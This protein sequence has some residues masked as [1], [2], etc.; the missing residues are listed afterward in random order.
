MSAT[1]K[2]H[3]SNKDQEMI[4][5]DE[6]EAFLEAIFKKNDLEYKVNMLLRKN[7]G[8]N[9][10]INGLPIRR[11]AELFGLVNIVFF[12]P[13]DLDII[14]DGP[15][16]RRKFID[17][18]LSQLDKIYLDDLS[19]YNKVL[20]QR[21]KLLKD[22]ALGEDAKDTLDIWDMQLV[23]YGIKIIER[24]SQFIQELNDIVRIIH[25][26]LSGDK[27]ELIISY[28]P[29]VTI[30]DFEKKLYSTR[31]RDLK[32]RVT[33]IGPHKDDICFDINGKD[34]RKYG[35]QGQQRT[36]ALSLKLSEIELVKKKV[37]DEPILLLDDVLSELDSKRQN[38]LLNS[39][40]DIQTIVTCTGLD[41]FINNRFTINKIYKVVEGKVTVEN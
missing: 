19:N 38:Y 35:S 9:I 7:K 6:D 5:F 40:K 36:S 24:R 39:I 17:M 37:H 14:K 25:S 20:A 28:E 31:D 10:A 26:N 27:E 3:R 13:Q 41:E 32:L 11:A 12:S 4:K 34:V 29:D 2:S 18:E 21:N 1:T 23:R 8:K 16:A 33:N 15:A 30:E 22:L